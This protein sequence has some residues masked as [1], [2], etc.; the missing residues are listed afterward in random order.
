MSK[1]PFF[2]TRTQ[3]VLFFVKLTLLAALAYIMVI[4]A[5]SPAPFHH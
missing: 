4:A 1:P 3:A 5:L 2:E